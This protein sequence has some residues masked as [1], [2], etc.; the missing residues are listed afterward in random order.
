MSDNRLCINHIFKTQGLISIG[1]NYEIKD[2]WGLSMVYTPGVAKCC[3]M[4]K[5]QPAE[6]YNLTS[7]SNT[8]FVMSNGSTHDSD[9][10]NH[11]PSFMLPELE[12]ISYCYKAQGNINGYPIVFDS[13]IIKDAKD[14][15]WMLKALSP[16][17]AALELYNVDRKYFESE[18]E[19]LDKVSLVL[20]LPEHRE[21][22]RDLLKDTE[23]EAYFTNL[24]L[25]CMVKTLAYHRKFGI[26]EHALIDKVITDN[27]KSFDNSNE[28]SLKSMIVKS[29]MEYYKFDL[30][31]V[32]TLVMRTVVDFMS[33][34]DQQKLFYRKFKQSSS[35]NNAIFIHKIF[36]GMV[37]TMLNVH[38]S[39]LKTFL[40][41][42][43]AE[44]VH[45][46]CDKIYKHPEEDLIYT[47]K[48]NY[49]AI[50]TNGTA[51]LGLGD[52]GPRGGLPVMEGKACLFKQLGEVNVLSLA[53]ET[54]GA[55]E[56]VKLIRAMADSWVG[57]NLEDIGAPDCFI[58]EEKLK[59][60]LPIPVFHDDQHGTAIVVLAGLINAL[61]VA[62]K[63]Y[64]KVKIAVNGAG[65]AGKAVIDL[66]LE[67]GFPSIVAVDSKGAIYEGRS[68]INKDSYKYE[69]ASRT[70]SGHEKGKLED[71]L[72]G[73]DVFIGLSVPN[74]L[75]KE[76][77]LTMNKEP[78][79]FALANPDPE[80]HPD[81]AKNAGAIVVATG[82]SD[83]NNQINNSL[84]FPGVFKGLIDAKSNKI[85]MPIKRKAA[86]AL[87]HTVPDSELNTNFILPYSLDLDVAKV[88]AQ[89][90]LVDVECLFED[91][92]NW[93][94]EVKL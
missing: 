60:T 29:I 52:I 33:H 43:S 83:F 75:K 10:L 1:S 76:W 40:K 17:T 27:R 57:I 91:E 31:G 47:I 58:V 71:I 21:K 7:V 26:L 74:S 85:D 63:D 2:R 19:A 24:L 82:R 50:I 86:E 81:D 22:L 80:I 77:V 65:A 28:Y 94:K 88:I 11:K 90:I 59:N 69:L 79:V 92:P 36:N 84:V 51:V 6:L 41:Q 4:I 12:L 67:Y 93:T 70:N 55:E 23:S 54:K 78:I 14:I 3:T 18:R 16:S 5:E 38:I 8:I 37:K 20:I 72:K 15:L 53:I 34:S 89:S 68:D 39:D 42:V 45:S 44:H 73:K 62:K 9:Y 56:T 61:K 64:K 46:L 66:L 87:A 48:K 32:S 13:N 35:D 25:S 49:C 30:K